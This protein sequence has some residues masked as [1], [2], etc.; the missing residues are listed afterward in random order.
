[1]EKG[2]KT[3][4]YL[5]I[6]AL[7]LSVF[8]EIRGNSSERAGGASESLKA[9]PHP[10]NSRAEPEGE[11]RFRDTERLG[12]ARRG[13]PSSTAPGGRRAL[14]GSFGMCHKN[15]NRGSGSAARRLLRLLLP[16]FNGARRNPS[17]LS[18][19]EG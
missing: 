8:V 12:E 7:N 18:G 16:G 17:F 2:R 6:L 5:S 11:K 19:T 4:A 15:E 1:M 3:A 10:V 9:R 13:G 14:P